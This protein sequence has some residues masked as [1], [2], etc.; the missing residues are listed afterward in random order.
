MIIVAASSTQMNIG[1]NAGGTHARRT[2]DIY[3]HSI[4]AVL[5]VSDNFLLSIIVIIFR[6]VS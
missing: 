6:H 2:P 5:A 1:Q 4:L 3:I